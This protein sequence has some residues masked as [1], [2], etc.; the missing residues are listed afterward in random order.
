MRPTAALLLPK[1]EIQLQLHTKQLIAELQQIVEGAWG[2]YKNKQATQA[3]QLDIEVFADCYRL[4]LYAMD[5]SNSQIGHR[6]LMLG[7][8]EGLLV[9]EELYPD[10]TEYHC[11]N[12]KDNA[13][14]RAFDLAQKE[15]FVQ[16]FLNCWSQL[17]KTNLTTSIYLVFHDADERLDLVK[18]KWVK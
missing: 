18:N 3:Q 6:S 9:E 10:F 15:I 1:N 8:E 17:D 7:F 14:L 16:W 11:K 5:A 13:D 4:V 2:L 12:D